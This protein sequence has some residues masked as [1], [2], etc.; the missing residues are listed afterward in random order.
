MKPQWC[1]R[2][3]APGEV[4]QYR[5]QSGQTCTDGY[6]RVQVTEAFNDV[7]EDFIIGYANRIRGGVERYGLFPDLDIE[8]L[9]QGPVT[10]SGGGTVTV[11]H[12][13][14]AG[15]RLRVRPDPNPGI[16]E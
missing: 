3:T 8:I 4:D 2:Y 15:A 7:A 12:G 5:P 9:A 6:A 16:P 11:E 10:A 13:D 1:E 14:L